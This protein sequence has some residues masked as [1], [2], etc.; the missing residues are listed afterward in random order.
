MCA[1]T[2][3]QCSYKHAICTIGASVKGVYQ[4]QGGIEKYLQS[5]PEGGFWAGQN[6]VAKFLKFHT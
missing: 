5:F 3:T 1:C 4:L 6:K 2:N